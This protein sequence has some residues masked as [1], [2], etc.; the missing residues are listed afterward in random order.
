MRLFTQFIVRPLVADKI[1]TATTVLGVALGIAVVIAI[2]LTNASSVRGFETALETVAGKTAVE[3]VGTGGIDET[4]LPSLGWL[5]EYGVASPVIEGNA[6]MVVGDLTALSQRDLEAV[7]VLGID[8]LR[9]MPF[10]DYQLLDIGGTGGR[11]GKAAASERQHADSHVA[12]VPRDPDQRAIGGDHRETGEAA[13][14]G[15]RQRDADDVWRP[16]RHPRHPR[17]AEG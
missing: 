12:E 11:S 14:A 1:R 7:R 13:R 2:Q 3:M 17:P 8:I 6:A 9:D 5:R 15:H 16:R 10:R 4:L